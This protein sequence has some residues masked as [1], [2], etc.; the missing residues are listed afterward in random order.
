MRILAPLLILLSLP[1][2]AA[3]Q[4]TTVS[5]QI[6]RKLVS[7]VVQAEDARTIASVSIQYGQAAWRPEYGK[8]LEAPSASK[9]TQLG[10][11][12]WTSLDTMAPIEIAGVRIEAGCWF[13]GLRVDAE[14]GA[15]LLVFDAV[16][17]MRDGLLPGSTP[18]YTGEKKPIASAKLDVVRGGATEEAPLLVLEFTADEG[19]ARHAA[20][21]IRWGNAVASAPVVLHVI[22]ED[23]AMDGQRELGGKESSMLATLDRVTCRGR[24]PEPRRPC[25]S[26]A[27]ASQVHSRSNPPPCER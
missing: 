27:A 18:L 21:A 19:D 13:L 9:Y 10:K 3:A 4:R 23:G 2:S 17:A 14:G 16:Q 25:W 20:F 5:P 22:G 1:P 11:G 8:E 15:H 26:Q 7:V 24:E 6:E 12:H